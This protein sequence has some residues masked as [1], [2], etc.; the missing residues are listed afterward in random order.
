MKPPQYAPEFRVAIDAEPLPA[1]ARGSV[2]AIS[3]QTGLEG[4]DRVELSI[5][6]ESLRWLDHPLFALDRRLALS[7]GYAPAPLEQ[8]FVGEIVGHTATFPSGGIPMLWADASVIHD[9]PTGSN[10][11]TAAAVIPPFKNTRREARSLDELKERGLRREARVPKTPIT[12]D[13]LEHQI[14]HEERI[15][16]LPTDRPLTHAAKVATCRHCKKSFARKMGKA[17]SIF[18]SGSALRTAGRCSWIT[19]I[20]WAGSS[21]GSC[22]R[23]IT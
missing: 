18:S 12:F 11:R 13:T 19:A 21:S 22:R 2:T 8:V 17:T 3:C 20:R 1:A 23:S 4:A 9:R 15:V 10:P 7:L 6:N 16:G 14:A 5:A